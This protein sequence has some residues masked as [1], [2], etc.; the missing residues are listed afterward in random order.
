MLLVPILLSCQQPSR[1][2]DDGTSSAKGLWL[3]QESDQSHQQQRHTEGVVLPSGIWML[4]SY[5]EAHDRQVDRPAAVSFGVLAAGERQL[6]ADGYSYDASHGVARRSLQGNFLPGAEMAL[7]YL[8]YIAGE[9]PAVQEEG[10]LQLRADEAYRQGADAERLSGD[11]ANG[12]LSLRIGQ[13]GWVSAISSG[14]QAGYCNFTGV[15]GAEDERYNAYW[16]VLDLGDDPGCEIGAG[17]SDARQFEAVAYFIEDAACEQT[18][19]QHTALV[20]G[21]HN[22]RVAHYYHRLCKL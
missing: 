18:S 16:G 14:G 9:P 12:E 8:N 3:G 4:A 7:S 19:G 15:L 21:L 5:G 11:Y 6:S 20:L 22:G 1:S 10:A 13:D 2:G 17:G